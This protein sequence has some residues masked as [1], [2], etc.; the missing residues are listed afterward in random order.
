MPSYQ[1]ERPIPGQSLTEEPRNAPYER[2]PEIVDPE[3]A[4]LVHLHR[5]NTKEAVENIGF[6]LELGV[7]VRTM[8]EGILRSAVTNGIHTIDTSLIIAPVIHEFIKTT[9]DA[10]KIDYDEGFEEQDTGQLNYQRRTM[11]AA[12]RLKELK[13]NPTKTAKGVVI[14]DEAPEDSQLEMDLGDTGMDLGDT[15][16]APEEMQEP[17]PSDEGLGL[18]SRG[19]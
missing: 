10:L 5:L 12:K 11:L 3:E 1:F 17:M 8:T 9:A 19:V 15:G 18:M 13:S 7:D 6:F 14:P 4:L 2:P 16:P